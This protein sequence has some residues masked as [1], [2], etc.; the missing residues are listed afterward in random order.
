MNAIDLT[1]DVPNVDRSTSQ[2][3]ALELISAFKSADMSLRLAIEQDNE[4]NIIR[5]SQVVDQQVQA[6]LG[7]E[8]GDTAERAALLRFLVDRFVLREDSG[9]EMRRAVCDKL[10]ALA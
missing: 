6:M 5:F 8:T 4:A 7:F 10:L 9:T 2:L 3:S 1:N